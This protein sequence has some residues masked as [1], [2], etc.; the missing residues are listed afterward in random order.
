MQTGPRARSGFPP[1]RRIVLKRTRSLLIRHLQAH[2]F[3]PVSWLAHLPRAAKNRLALSASEPDLS[4]EAG[5]ARV[6]RFEP[7]LADAEMSRRSLRLLAHAC[8][9]EVSSARRRN[10]AR[11]VEAVQGVEG[12][13]PLF[14]L[15]PEGTCP[16]ALPVAVSD[17]D[18]FRRRLAAGPGLGVKQM[19]PWF[20]PSADWSDFPFEAAL[21]RSVFIL[22]VHQSLHES[23]IELMIST[24]RRWPR[25]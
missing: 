14:P 11:L 21:K 5:L 3:R 2:S 7:Q 15:L 16:L 10:Y 1:P 12:L 8:P 25:A 4:T 13:R 9:V 23:E 24:M 18:S 22:P 20:H 6:A 19:W 17:P